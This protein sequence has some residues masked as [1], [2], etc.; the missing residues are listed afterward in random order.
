MPQELADLIQT[1]P[2]V[3]K[4]V[5]ENV[6][7]QYGLVWER[8]A[9][10]IQ[11]KINPNVLPMLEYDEKKSILTDSIY[12]NILIEGDNYHA[13][14]V[15]NY[16]HS[17][18][19]DMIYI[20]PPYNL[21]GELGAFRYNDKFVTEHD[22]YRHSKWLS[23][24][25]NRLNL[26]KNLLNKN[27]LLLISINDV[28]DSQ[29]RLLCDDIFSE[30]NFITKL[31]W[32]TRENV[33]GRSVTGIS[34][35]HEYV[36]VY[37]KSEKSRFRG[38]MIDTKKFSNP[39]N[40]PRGPWMS[41][42][43]DGI[44][45]KNRRPNLHYDIINPKTKQKYFPNPANGWRFSKQTFTKLMKDDRII[46][47]KNPK[48]KPRLKRYLRELKSQFTGFSSILDTVTYSA[49]TRELRDIMGSE[50]F[51]FPKPVG[52]LIKLLEQHVSKNSIVLDFFAGSGTTGHAVLELNKI[53]GGNRK[54]ILCTNNENNICTQVCQP[55]ISKIIQGYKDKSGNNICG[56]NS[57]LQYF[58]I[59]TKLRRHMDRR[60]I[61]Q[62]IAHVLC[63]KESCFSIVK[64]IGYK[65]IIY[66]NQNDRYFGIVYT[67]GA[68]DDYL[69]NIRELKKTKK[70]KS[71]TI[72]TYA[73]AHDRTI[74][75]RL[76]KSPL[77]RTVAIPMPL[78]NLWDR[79]FEK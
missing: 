76:R 43:I 9:E 70:I 20:D 7:K 40:D 6:A 32:K 30:T 65:Y 60:Q 79:W 48:S 38:K 64:K 8:Y 4:W 61:A 37:R 11:E 46:W 13:L 54:F 69:K 18:K 51:K 3:K 74:P 15:L 1:K 68:V 39:D 21:G 22:G 12:D 16:T 14:Q 19:I 75:S 33:D 23:F 44:A 49:G 58:K 17:G 77:V 63:V 5:N 31:I 57:N 73:F 62:K 10:G 2:A 35:D 50:S 25:W 26:A 67:T 24:M 41:S 45:T 47:P 53:D 72:P 42:P 59:N 36:L 56:L 34:T 66:K 71:K 55:R 78:L 27:G 52:L 28:E 29:L